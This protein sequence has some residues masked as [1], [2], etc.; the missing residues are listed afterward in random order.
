[1]RM[2][3][4]IREGGERYSGVLAGREWKMI[5][6]EKMKEGERISK[7]NNDIMVLNQ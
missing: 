2:R 3:E 4:K 7:I 6:I 5:N 1:M